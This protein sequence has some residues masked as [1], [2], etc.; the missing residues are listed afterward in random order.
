MGVRISL[1]VVDLPQFEAYLEEPLG[2][3]LWYYAENGQN[4]QKPLTF[5]QEV[6]RSRVSN[7]YWAVPDKRVKIRRWPDKKWTSL[8]KGAEYPDSFLLE[9]AHDYLIKEES[10][11]LRNLFDCLSYC[12]ALNWV[13][14]MSKGYRRAWIGSLLDYADND[15]RIS[16]DKYAAIV[17]L[18]QKVLRHYNCGKPLPERRFTLSDFRFPVIP[19]GDESLWMGV[20]T[21]S[22]LAA[23]LRFLRKL[24]SE[25]EPFFRAPPESTGIEPDTDDEWNEWVWKMISQLRRAE[26][27]EFE[28]PYLVSFIDS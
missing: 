27:L 28:K 6:E 22:E 7:L 12:P 9:K 13:R 17:T 5:F 14:S 10:F 16:S 18:F 15:P 20:W 8:A 2:D 24:T 26:T 25:P 1:Y 4:T 23:M 21:D 3:I 19:T 11:A